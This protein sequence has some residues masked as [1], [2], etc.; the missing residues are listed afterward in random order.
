MQ[1]AEQPTTRR[2]RTVQ[3]ANSTLGAMVAVTLLLATI[4]LAAFVFTPRPEAS[5]VGGSSAISASAGLVEFRHGEQGA[6]GAADQGAQPGL[7]EFRHGEQ[8]ATQQNI[9]TLDP[10]LVEFRRGER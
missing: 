7:V 3:V 1:L 9:V 6:T 4:G 5:E 8:G 10:A 2:L